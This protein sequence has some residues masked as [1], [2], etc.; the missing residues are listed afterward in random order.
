MVDGRLITLTGA[1]E[2]TITVAGMSR[3]GTFEVF[4]SRGAWALLFG[5]LLLQTFKAIH[6]YSLDIVRIPQGTSWI[7]LSNQFLSNNGT[8][9]ALLVGLTTDI[10]QCV[11]TQGGS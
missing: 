7:E 11:K 5:K 9:G 2:G 8:T 1:W 3:Q 4:D 6:D 10:K